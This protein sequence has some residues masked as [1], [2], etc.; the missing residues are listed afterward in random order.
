MAAR[1]GAVPGD[2][3]LDGCQSQ[4]DV[5]GRTG[6]FKIAEL[7]EHHFKINP[8]SLIKC[9]NKRKLTVFMVDKINACFK[10]ELTVSTYP[11]IEQNE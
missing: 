6:G 11:L 1:Q 7:P 9:C 4:K 8:A 3:S 10:N 5:T 2:S